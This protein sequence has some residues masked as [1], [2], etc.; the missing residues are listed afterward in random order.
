M[1][2]INLVS[3]QIP[4]FKMPVPAGFPSPAADYMGESIDLNSEYIRNP[5]STFIIECEG[6]SMIEAFIPPKSR[7]LIDRSITAKNG[8]VIL[9]VV[10]GGFT[11]KYFQKTGFE[12]FLIP[13]NKKYKPIEIT[14]GMDFIVWGVVIA[15]VSIP[16]SNRTCML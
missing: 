2:A 10:D 5:S 12:C 8:D 9:A 15:I 7:L 4:Y 14:E 6:D 3:I 13:A 16:K 11:V 1:Q